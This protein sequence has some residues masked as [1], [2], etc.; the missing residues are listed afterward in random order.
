MGSLKTWSRVTA[1]RKVRTAGNF[2]LTAIRAKATAIV[3]LELA[4]MAAVIA[5]PVEG[6]QLS[7]LEL[8]TPH[9]IGPL[10]RLAK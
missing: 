2:A 8:A 10:G 1:T 5:S 6:D 3:R 7:E 9:A 4:A